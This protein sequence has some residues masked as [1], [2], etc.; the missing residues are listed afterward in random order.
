MDALNRTSGGRRMPPAFAVELAAL[1]RLRFAAGSELTAP[2]QVEQAFW[3]IESGLVRL[4]SLGEH[5]RDRNHDFLGAGEWVAGALSWRDG[6]VCCEGAAIGVQALKSTV[7]IR[8][9]LTFIEQRHRESPEVA[10]WLTDELMQLSSRRLQRE[11]DLLQLS[12]EQRYHALARER[13]ALVRMLAQHHIASWLGITP[14]ALSRIRRRS[15][16]SASSQSSS[17]D[18]H[19]KRVVG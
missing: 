8:L 18:G 7:A 1:A 16:I 10:A 4:Y 5:G 2:G 14:V 19:A 15:K 13:P 6:R 17:G 11:L 3:C 12:A 9:P